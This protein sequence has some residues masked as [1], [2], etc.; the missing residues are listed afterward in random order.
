MNRTM[1]IKDLLSQLQTSP[2]TV[3][4]KTVIDVIDSHY[5][6]TA[7]EFKNGELVNEQGTNLGSCKI[8]AFAQLHD[9]SEQ[10]TLSCFGDYYRQD[11]LQNPD[12]SDHGN[13]R[14]FMKTGWQGIQFSAPALELISNN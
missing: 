4:F 12:G 9:L 5:E 10:Q 7:V 6:F 1:M 13:I 2:D 14:N 11:V 8:F 3:E